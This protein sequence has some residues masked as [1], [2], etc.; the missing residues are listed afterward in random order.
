MR[1]DLELASH[2]RAIYTVIYAECTAIYTVMYTPMYTVISTVI[3]TDQ[4]T[5]QRKKEP[6]P[7]HLLPRQ[8]R[9]RVNKNPIIFQPTFEVVSSDSVVYYVPALYSRNYTDI[10]ILLI[11]L[12]V[13]ISFSVSIFLL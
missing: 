8:I 6:G 11:N 12:I 13:L 9:Y 10:C 5:V 1:P 2:A 4:S 3:Y 7:G